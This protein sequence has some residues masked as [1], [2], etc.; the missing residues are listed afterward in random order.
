[1]FGGILDR[2][3]YKSNF[4]A[5][6]G[7]LV[8][9][10]LTYC[11]FT[12][13]VLRT[14]QVSIAIPTIAFFGVVA[15]YLFKW[16]GVAVASLLLGAFVTYNLLHQPSV[17][18]PWSIVIALS[19]V[20]S[21]VVTVLCSEEFTHRWESLF[22]NLQDCKISLTH[23]SERLSEDQ[24]KA[25][26]E[27][28]EAAQQNQYLREQLK[29]ADER[30]ML[31]ERAAKLARDEISATNAHQEKIL[32][33]LYQTR[34]Q[35]ATLADALIV[36]QEKGSPSVASAR[37]VAETA[38]VAELQK[39]LI[40]MSQQY[41]EAKNQLQSFEE[42]AYVEKEKAEALRRELLTLQELQQASLD[43]EKQTDDAIKRHLE[44]I[45]DLNRQVETCLR[46]QLKLESEILVYQNKIEK[47][48]E[49][50]EKAVHD[51]ESDL[52]LLNGELQALKSEITHL[53][54]DIATANRQLNNVNEQFMRASQESVSCK[55]ELSSL[56][57]ERSQL[58][59]VVADIQRKL[60]ERE[61]EKIDLI[62]HID[63]L[64]TAHNMM[65][66]Q[67]ANKESDRE[68]RR[69][70]G[71]YNQLRNQFNEKTEVLASTRRELFQTQEKLAALQKDMQEAALDYEIE[72]N[73][74]FRRLLEQAD[75][76]LTAESWV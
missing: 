5:Q 1:M 35:N 8:G 14:T 75:Q 32:Q 70:N 21:F 22:K 66:T 31:L 41:S 2:T 34:Q 63:E 10:L 40:A 29:K 59:D 64:K 57:I 48:A 71:L 76:E 16:R 51:K 27:R 25:S 15:S 39:Q 28:G 23:V 47:M 58:K 74:M 36:L 24:K 37:S 65:A 4:W 54:E 52:Q 50:H 13:I 11:L 26:W 55:R 62:K 3:I 12:V 68:V 44:T 30:T 45:N 33:E 72:T 49:D 42:D 46:D 61:I 9:P 53:Q 7:P 67:L 73:E 18:W 19:A 60:Q 43:R 38:N 17:T 20:S 56:E 69:L 6:L